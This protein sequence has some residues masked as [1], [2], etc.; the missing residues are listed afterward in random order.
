MKHTL[1]FDQN[2]EENKTVDGKQANLLIERK[3]FVVRRE[4]LFQ[5]QLASFVGI[6]FVEML[7]NDDENQRKI[8][9]C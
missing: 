8:N 9:A 7:S 2:I 4:F 6:E 3:R 1:V 5:S